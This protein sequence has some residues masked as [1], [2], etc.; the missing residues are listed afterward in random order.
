VGVAEGIIMKIGGWRSRS[1][2]ER[3]AIVN[4]NDMADAILKLEEKAKQTLDGHNMVTL[5]TSTLV[6][7]RSNVTLN[8]A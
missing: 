4:Q 7:G 1:V 8:L 3:Y 5:A 6:V 2:F